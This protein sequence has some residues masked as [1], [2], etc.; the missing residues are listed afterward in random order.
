MCVLII[1]PGDISILTLRTCSYMSFMYRSFDNTWRAER[2]N[3]MVMIIGHAGDGLVQ[4]LFQLFEGR[5]FVGIEWSRLQARRGTYTWGHVDII[6]CE[7]GQT[8]TNGALCQPFV[9]RLRHAWF[10]NS[11]LPECS[12]SSFLLLFWCWRY[13]LV[14]MRKSLSYSVT[15]SAY[16]ECHPGMYNRRCVI[17]ITK[18]SGLVTIFLRELSRIS[19]GGVRHRSRKKHSNTEDDDSN[20]EFSRFL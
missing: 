3:T 8:F 10:G 11:W 17:F 5:L 7:K 19:S 15:R 9:N 6:E 4:A 13:C 18:L 16:V 1:S 2:M 14:A 20:D 12:C